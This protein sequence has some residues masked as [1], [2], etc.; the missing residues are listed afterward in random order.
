MVWLCMVGMFIFEYGMLCVESS[1]R[2]ELRFVLQWL[3]FYVL[4]PD[5]T[6]DS[7]QKVDCFIAFLTCRFITYKYKLS[8]N[9]LD[10]FVACQIERV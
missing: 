2:V 9:C 8:R 4:L 3:L 7:S 1:F 5:P 6:S 10:I